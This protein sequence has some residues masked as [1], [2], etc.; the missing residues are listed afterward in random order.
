MMN[1]RL[2][3]WYLALVQASAAHANTD[4][5]FSQSDMQN[6]VDTIDTEPDPIPMRWLNAM[7]GRIFFGVYRTELLEQVCVQTRP[8][9]CQRIG[10]Q[11]MQ[12]I[13]KK[14]MKKLSKVPRPSF[15]GPIVV[16]EVNVGTF[17]PMFVDFMVTPL[18]LT[19]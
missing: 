8:A 15:L 18:K 14:I 17:P 19:L 12:F 11:F 16:R 7:F 3:D 13:I 9:I 4:D 1:V 2:E 10:S 5:V 6:L